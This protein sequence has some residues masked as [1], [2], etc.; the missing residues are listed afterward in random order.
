MLKNQDYPISFEGQ[1]PG[2]DT[3][4]HRPTRNICSP[5]TNIEMDGK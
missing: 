4:C 3:T 2:S 1:L 5:A